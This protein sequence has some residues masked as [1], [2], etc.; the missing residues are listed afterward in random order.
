MARFATEAELAAFLGTI[1]QDYA[2][3]AATLWQKGIRTS[4]QLP[5]AR[6]HI[7]A[8]LPEVHMNDIKASAGSAGEQ[9]ACMS[10]VPL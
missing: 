7:S 6:D 2:Q 5:N 1:D 3:Y 8:G 10:V 9:L 4:G